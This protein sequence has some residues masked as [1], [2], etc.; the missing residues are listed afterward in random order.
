MSLVEKA[1]EKMKAEAARGER[2]EP[3]AVAAPPTNRPPQAPRHTIHVS[4]ERLRDARLLPPDSEARRAENEFRAIKRGMIAQYA[5]S[6]A[7]S[8]AFMV[9]SALPGEGKTFTSVNLAMSIAAGRDMRAV[10]VDADVAK[11]HISRDFG[12]EHERGLL[13][14]LAGGE[15]T[16]DDLVIGTDIPNLSIVSAGKPTPA[17]TELL[18]SAR[19][20]RL[21]ERS[22]ATRNPTVYIF[23]SPP[24]LITTEARALADVLSN[25]LL[26]VRAGSTPHS[27]VRE[28]L[29]AIG[30]NK[31]LSLVLNEDPA[32]AQNGYQ[33]GKYPYGG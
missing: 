33:Y 15:E 23:D 25:V 24:V 18:S 28:A 3:V 32:A 2:P 16:L 7:K 19:M 13:D 11:Q 30:E 5:A 27:A 31:N 26:I 22:L 9:A 12:V 8:Y 4:L 29:E 21:L 1:L 10:L 6:Q 20:A 17:A 14:A